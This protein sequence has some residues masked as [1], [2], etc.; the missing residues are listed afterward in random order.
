MTSLPP[1]LACRTEDLSTVYAGTDDDAALNAGVERI[2]VM[3]GRSPIRR[4][5]QTIG[6]LR[7]P[8]GR[9]TNRMH[10]SMS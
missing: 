9:N 7:H 1:R 3:L 6:R 2:K 8:P 5:Y 4:F 10:F